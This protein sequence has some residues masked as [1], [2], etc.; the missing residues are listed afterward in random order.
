MPMNAYPALAAR[1]TPIAF[2]L[3]SLM[4]LR[5]IGPP[6]RQPPNWRKPEMP[7]KPEYQPEELPAS[8]Y[9]AGEVALYYMPEKPYEVVVI[10]PDTRGRPN[11][12]QL[13]RGR[14]LSGQELPF[15]M[16]AGAIRKLVKQIAN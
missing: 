12:V 11:W 9:T 1:G 2:S 14:D 3:N 8:A 6:N 16:P 5:G 13:K 10:G 4:I 15:N 7:R